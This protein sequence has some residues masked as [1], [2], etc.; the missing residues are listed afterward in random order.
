[1]SK[2]TLFFKSKLH[3]SVDYSLFTSLNSEDYIRLFIAD[4]LIYECGNYAI[5]WNSPLLNY[6]VCFYVIN[7]KNNNRP[8]PIGN[9]SYFTK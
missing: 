5:N 4:T 7:H 8:I 1:M 6:C 3:C 9:A 2:S